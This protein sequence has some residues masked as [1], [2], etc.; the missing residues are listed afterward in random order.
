MSRGARMRRRRHNSGGPAR[1]LL[2]GGGTL[3]CALILGA[4]AAVGYVVNVLDEAPKLD[5]LHPI[6]GAGSSQ[7][8]AADGA[9]LGFIQADEL[10]TPVSWSEIPASRSNATVAI[11]DQR[12]YNHNAV[13]ATP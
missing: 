1:I 9:R 6:L 11:E 5:K 8:F 7:V 13:D 10:R 2:I 3:A 4:I 12:F